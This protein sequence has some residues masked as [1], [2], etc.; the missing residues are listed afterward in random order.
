MSLQDARPLSPH[1][2]IYKWQITSVLSILH[3]LTGVGFSAG[4][5][6]FV[7]WLCLLTQSNQTY[8][9][10]MSM[11]KSSL[12]QI[13]IWAVV[14]SANYH[15]SNGLRHLTFDAGYGFSL[16]VVT[17]SGWFALSLSFFVTLSL[18]WVWRL[19]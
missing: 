15:F 18:F 4:L 19:S 9:D 3:R 12:G 14:F 1:I 11:I 10:L 17:R 2:Q 5:I 7:G 8:T 16:P 13:C 6:G